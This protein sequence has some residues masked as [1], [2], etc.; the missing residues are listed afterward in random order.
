MLQATITGRIGGVASGALLFAL[1]L[2]ARP[3]IA[4]VV[5]SMPPPPKKAIVETPTGPE[6]E[7]ITSAGVVP[8]SAT[9]SSYAGPFS[10][11][12]QQQSV[13]VGEV[14]LF[15]YARARSGTFGTYSSD[16]S[17]MSN[18]IRVYSYPRFFPQWVWG[19]FWGGW[20]GFGFPLCR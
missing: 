17:Y 1:T 7:I 3:C 20:G 10:A 18:G 2:L 12:G 11:S 15:R 16:G 9:A 13:S 14:A 4:D 5:I 6:A 19:P 8:Y